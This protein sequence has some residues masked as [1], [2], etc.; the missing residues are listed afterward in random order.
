M[1]QTVPISAG[2]ALGSFP[3]EHVKAED[4]F[5]NMVCNSNALFEEKKPKAIEFLFELSGKV[6]C[7]VLALP[8][9]RY[10]LDEAKIERSPLRYGRWCMS[11]I[12]ELLQFR[13]SPT[14]KFGSTWVFLLG[15]LPDLA[16][17]IGKAAL[18]RDP[19]RVDAVTMA[20]KNDLAV[21]NQTIGVSSVRESTAPRPISVQF[22]NLAKGGSSRSW[23][24]SWV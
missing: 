14:A 3:R 17:G 24:R 8:V 16:D 19:I 10:M 15:D 23:I 11:N 4:G 9:K 1:H 22:I 5:G 21:S 18:P 20:D 6:A 13:E 7:C 12:P 2:A